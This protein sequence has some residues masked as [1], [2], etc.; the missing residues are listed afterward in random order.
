MQN[1]RTNVP[2]ALDDVIQMEFYNTLKELLSNNVWQNTSTLRVTTTKDTYY[3]TPTDIGFIN[4]LIRVYD[5]NDTDVPATMEVPG[6]LVL[7]NFPSDAQTYYVTVAMN[8]IDPAD[9]NNYPQFPT[10]ILDKHDTCLM[11]G[12]IGKLLA[13]PA[14][15]YSNQQLAIYHLKRFRSLVAQARVESLHKNV[16]RGQTWAFPQQFKTHRRH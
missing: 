8:V 11:V 15:T 3:I 7:N 2:G 9:S 1:V 12:T 6:T 4:R 14:K 13:Q 5:I 16:G 10:W